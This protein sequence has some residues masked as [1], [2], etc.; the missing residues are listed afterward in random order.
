MY[1]CAADLPPICLILGD[2]RIEYKSRVEENAFMAISLK[3]VG[4]KQ[5]EFYEM[6]GLDHGT[7]G[8]GGMIVMRK[9]I[10]KYS[11]PTSVKRP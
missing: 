1:H 8:T 7:V 9:F 5:T 11:K 2:R 4:H 3:N 6:G 10:E